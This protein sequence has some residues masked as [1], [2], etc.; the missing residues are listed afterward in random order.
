MVHLVR[1]LTSDRLYEN[2]LVP[3]SLSSILVVLVMR[4]SNH[5]DLKT[6]TSHN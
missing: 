5:L 1:F 4:N 2:Y 3:K 6:F